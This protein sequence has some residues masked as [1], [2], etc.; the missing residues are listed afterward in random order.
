M[1]ERRCASLS[2]DQAIFF[3]ESSSLALL[4][5]LDDSLGKSVMSDPILDVVLKVALSL[6]SAQVHPYD[7][8]HRPLS[9]HV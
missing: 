7:S 6:M 1:K 2:E 3:P 5:K 9:W 4:D 8:K